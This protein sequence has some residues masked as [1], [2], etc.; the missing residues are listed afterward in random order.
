M[1]YKFD[2]ILELLKAIAFL[3]E[4]S[5]LRVLKASIA[6]LKNTGSEPLQEIE[7]M[8]FRML[9]PRLQ[10]EKER[11]LKLS[12]ARSQCGKKGGRGKAKKAIALL[13]LEKENGL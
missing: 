13:A 1:A 2:I 8:A 11:E 10:E 3:P 9:L 12:L 7:D 4:V 6:Y 5:Q